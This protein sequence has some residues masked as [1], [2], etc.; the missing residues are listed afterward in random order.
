MGCHTRGVRSWFAVCVLAVLAGRAR[1][2][3]VIMEPPIVQACRT[4]PS[5]SKLMDCMKQHGLTA[6]VVR[7]L[8]DA[9]LLQVESA[10]STTHEVE[11][12]ALYVS[13]STGWTIG[14]LLEA[15]SRGRDY[16]LQRFERVTAGA[17]HGYRFD[18]ASTQPTSVSLDQVTSE[19][20]LSRQVQ[21]VF[22]AGTSYSCMQLVPRCSTI[23]FGQAYQVFAGTI[24]VTGDRVKLTGAGSV[25]S[26]CSAPGEYTLQ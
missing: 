2:K 14:G 20:A 12:F 13:H 10:G 9:K 5:W 21:T 26:S 3:I 17:Y 1:A 23:V 24:D 6:T 22:C 4:A 11:A 25:P 19:R 8:D 15:G 16:E 18:L 7:S